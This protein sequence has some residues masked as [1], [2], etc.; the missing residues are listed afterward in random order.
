M[1]VVRNT[2]RIIV[3]LSTLVVGMAKAA[4]ASHGQALYALMCSSC[5]RSSTTA[6]VRGIVAS[7]DASLAAYPATNIRRRSR[8]PCWSGTNPTLTIG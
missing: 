2:L 8:K 6:L 4:D 5:T 3:C 7:S 1:N